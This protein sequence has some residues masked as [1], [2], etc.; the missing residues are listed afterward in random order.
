V[1]AATAEYV[2]QGETVMARL[3]SAL[4][5][6]N[7]TKYAVRNVITTRAPPAP[8]LV[9]KAGGVMTLGSLAVLCVKPYYLF[10]LVR[11]DEGIE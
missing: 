2:A 1:L 8:V 7:A 11:D 10:T 4:C 9:R 6:S 5:T 3:V